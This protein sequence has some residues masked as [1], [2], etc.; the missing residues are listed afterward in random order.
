M[1]W[2]ALLCIAFAALAP[3]GAQAGPKTGDP[4]RGEAL[5]NQQCSYCHS[6]SAR[7]TPTS[8]AAPKR[9]EAEP[10]QSLEPEREEPV[11]GGIEKR[12]P[13]LEGLLR[14]APGAVAGFPYRITMQTD[15]PTWTEADLDYWIY[16]HARLGETDRADLIAYLKKVTGG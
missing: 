4:L 14:R 6:L 11:L 8:S 2:R 15:S 12:G 7:M 13:H 5:Y 3:A 9:L 16:N 1:S 10:G